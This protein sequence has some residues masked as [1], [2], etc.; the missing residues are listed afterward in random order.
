MTLSAKCV[1]NQHKASRQNRW[2]TATN[3]KQDAWRDTA[4]V[5]RMNSDVLR[6][7]VWE[8]VLS[9]LSQTLWGHGGIF[10]EWYVILTVVLY[11]VKLLCGVQT[12]SNSAKVARNNPNRSPAPPIS[13]SL[14]LNEPE[15]MVTLVTVYSRSHELH[16]ERDYCSYCVVLCGLWQQKISL[17]AKQIT[18]LLPVVTICTTRCNIKQFYVL[19]TQCIYVFCVDLRTNSH[20]FPIQH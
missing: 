20:Y 18:H 6:N 14:S 12:A 8:T 1:A 15:V 13:G 3:Q 9:G 2:M 19:P 11:T 10:L 4:D 5:I 17:K 7:T 16:N